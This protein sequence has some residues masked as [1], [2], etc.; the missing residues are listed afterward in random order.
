MTSR[1]GEDSRL[2]PHSDSDQFIR[3]ETDSDT[4]CGE[5]LLGRRDTTRQ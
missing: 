5:L 1:P 3:V 2:E 4:I